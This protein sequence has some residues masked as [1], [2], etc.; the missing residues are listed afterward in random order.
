MNDK[1]KPWAGSYKELTT[2]SP[3]DNHQ[4]ENNISIRNSSN[5]ENVEHDFPLDRQITHSRFETLR[6]LR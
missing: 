4:K 5:K 6:L 1:I 3:N 2:I